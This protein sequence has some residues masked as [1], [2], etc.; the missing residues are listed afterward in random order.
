MATAESSHT[1]T[2][3]LDRLAENTSGEKVS[4]GDLLH[5]LDTRSYGPLLLA[6]GLIAASPLGMVPGMSIVTG[7]I[8]IVLSAQMLFGMKH[9]WLPKRLLS[10]EFD[11]DRVTATREKLKPWLRW[12]ERPI[13]ARYTK[14]VQPPVTQLIALGCIGLS[15]LFYPLALVPFGV[16]LPA[17]AVTL[18][19]LALAARDGLLAILAAVLTAAAGWATY[20]FWPF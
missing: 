1:L 17:T 15:L 14:L 5:S 9:P 8:I 18:F 3:L 20:A 10:L 2:D 4:L 11:R 7:S 13:R 19:A 6:A 12:A 16:F